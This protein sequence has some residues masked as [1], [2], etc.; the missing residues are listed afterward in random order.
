MNREKINCTGLPKNLVNLD[1]IHY[2][3][4]YRHFN[5]KIRSLSEMQGFYIG[6]KIW[7]KNW[8]EIAVCLLY[9]ESKENRKF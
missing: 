2:R 6:M 7:L 5:E 3:I 9:M 1:L 4:N 8:L